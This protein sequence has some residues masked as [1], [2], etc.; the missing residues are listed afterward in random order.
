MVKWCLKI[1]AEFKWQWNS[2][3][4][5]MNWSV[6]VKYPIKIIFEIPFATHWWV[7]SCN[8]KINGTLEFVCI[9]QYLQNYVMCHHHQHHRYHNNMIVVA[10]VL[11]FILIYGHISSSVQSLY[12]LR[13]FP[14]LFAYELCTST[15]F[16]INLF[17]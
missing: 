11:I 2:N 6:K 7:N 15:E 14:L 4:M 9:I 12:N 1:L 13:L 17:G 5:T 10:F 3:E 8:N 16:M